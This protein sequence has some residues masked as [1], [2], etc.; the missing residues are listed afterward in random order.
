[1][2]ITKNSFEVTFSINRNCMLDGDFN[3]AADW[4][5]VSA[6]KGHLE[7]YSW[8]I[9]V[10]WSE[11]RSVV[12]DSLRLQGLYSPGSLQA[13]ILDWVA[14]PFSRGIFPTQGSNPGLLHCRWILYQMSHNQG[15]H[16][17]L[18]GFNEGW[19]Q[20]PWKWHSTYYR[21]T[22]TLPKFLS[23]INFHPVNYDI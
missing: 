7:P 16:G 21:F 23:Y 10:K 8:S 22:Y 9:E 11:G 4:I 13:R 3:Q 18:Q 17:L 12:S 19:V 6:I 2:N 5:L 15:K 20:E 14:F 1:M